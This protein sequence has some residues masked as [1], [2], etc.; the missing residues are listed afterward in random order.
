MGDITIEVLEAEI[1]RLR[2][3]VDGKQLSCPTCEQR[4]LK[5]NERQRA[6]LR[7]KMSNGHE[8]KSAQ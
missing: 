8:G 5:A 6:Y 3:I 2:A 1:A 7:K 4:R